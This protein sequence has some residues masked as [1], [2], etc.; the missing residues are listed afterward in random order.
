MKGSSDIVGLHIQNFSFKPRGYA[1]ARVSG[2]KDLGTWGARY[3][4][5]A[6]LV[7]PG[8]EASP[9]CSSDSRGPA[10]E[11]GVLWAHECASLTPRRVGTGHPREGPRRR[12]KTCRD[13]G[14]SGCRGIDC[15]QHLF[16]RGTG[17]EQYAAYA[18]TQSRPPPNFPRRARSVCAQYIEPRAGHMSRL[19]PRSSWDNIA[20]ELGAR[21]IPLHILI[22]A[23]AHQHV[24][25]LVLS[26]VQTA[27]PRTIDDIRTSLTSSHAP[28]TSSR[29]QCNTPTCTPTS[30]TQ[31]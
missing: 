5:A 9:R 15:L 30:G 28:A 13:N 2:S 11:Q 10:R 16:R 22:P 6:S 19:Y 1:R 24:H 26:R 4:Y 20:A 17:C 25:D 31:P 27:R 12:G 18:G 21:H 7:R 23:F 29:R 8:T 3:V 14:L